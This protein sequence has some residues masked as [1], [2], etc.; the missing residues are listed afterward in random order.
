MRNPLWKRILLADWP[1]RMTAIITGLFLL[2][3][4]LWISKEDGLW[5]P[6]TISLVS[7]TLGLIVLTYLIPRLHRFWR[8]VLQLVL[9]IGMH[10]Y[11][12]DY[13]FTSVKL[14]A[15]KDV[16]KWLTLNA[17]QIAPFIW[18]SL[19]A[20]VAYLF[21]MWAVQSKLRIFVLILVSV[22][23]FA[24][25]DSFSVIFLWQQ[26]AAVLLCGFSLLMLRHF[27]QLK[28][29]AP[30]IWE[31]IIEYPASIG[32][33]IV[34]IV[35]FTLFIGAISPTVDPV[36]TDPYTAWKVSR[37]ETVP[38]LGKGISTSASTVDAASGYSRDDSKLGGGF[39]YDYTPV[40]TVDTTK[41]TY[42]RGETRSLYNGK[43]WELSPAEKNLS[44]TRV[45]G[46]PMQTDPRFNM[47]L[48][49]TKEVTQ[50]IM[51][52]R[53]EVFPV[54]FGGFAIQ[55]IEEINKGENP[56]QQ[57]LW[58][59]RQSEL[60]FIDK[61]N[62]PKDYKIITQEPI[63]DEP[64]LRQAKSDYAQRPEWSEYL[65][66][67]AELPDRVKQLAVDITKTGTNPY[68]KAKLIEK[69]LSEHYPYT[70]T[71]DESKG[72]S[73][74]FVDRF[75]FEVKQGYCDYYST[76][77][78]VLARS[79]GLPARWVKGYSS[80]ASPIPDQ[81]RDFGVMSQFGED[82]DP[83]GAGTY[84]VRNSDA[85]SW[86]EVYFEGYGWISF[87]PTSGFALPNVF[88]EAA[89]EPTDLSTDNEPVNE[90]TETESGS[91]YTWLWLSAAGAAV[92]AVIASVLFLM[93]KSVSL[94]AWRTKRKQAQAV[95]F[96]Q[97]IIVEFEK[98]LR[99][100]RRKGYS[101]L[102]HETMREAVNRWS[103]QSKWM[104]QELETVLLLFERA[105]YSQLSSTEQDYWKV[106]Q[107]ITK[108]KEQMK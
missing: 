44:L 77:M 24:I 59:P 106:S 38:L 88:P 26:V 40:M 51:M 82:I 30:F 6:E 22:L 97:K 29:R 19:T 12:L 93:F 80:G 46:N 85:H 73:K 1:Q 67:P 81:I 9:I 56:Y 92:I 63:L 53:E 50:T 71:P 14:T 86:V 2:Q 20:W 52:D 34:L 94:K 91:N 11:V 7:G 13:H 35:I 57:L 100:S 3:F 4:V 54:I 78:T 76:S 62:Y 45:N 98:L 37:G 15:W 8:T 74:D 31:S 32:I 27:A 58:A 25:R 42:F 99:L 39:R 17:V 103:K 90:V 102:E 105:K 69:Y 87:E 64:G 43:G 18:F 60:R 47:S 89:V 79:I 36:L 72:K 21:A 10:G 33:P 41:R 70:N 65:Q 83:N 5:L 23:F 108:L 55:K 49:K 75:L 61:N 84:T 28:Q 48:L 68:D 66:L 16:L 107:S 95:N 101:R 96:N 104:K